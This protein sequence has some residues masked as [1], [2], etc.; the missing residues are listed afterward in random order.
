[1]PHFTMLSDIPAALQRSRRLQKVCLRT[2]CRER[3][4]LTNFRH[5]SEM[6]GWQRDVVLIT[7]GV[8]RWQRS[9]VAV[10]S[11]LVTV[12]DRCDIAE[13]S[14]GGLMDRWSL[15]RDQINNCTLY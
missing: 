13:T 6:S 12:V 2:S 14:F 4:N 8:R 7:L 10:R 5:F 1:M 9:D 11:E 15:G 3:I